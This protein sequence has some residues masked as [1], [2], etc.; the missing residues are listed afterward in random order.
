MLRK[1]FSSI[2]CKGKAKISFF[3]NGEL[4]MIWE[5]NFS[6]YQCETLPFLGGTHICVDNCAIV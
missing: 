4:W 5:L 2:F 1:I 3:Q 6:E